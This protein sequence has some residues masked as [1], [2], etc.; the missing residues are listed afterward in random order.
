MT[1]IVVT[2]GTGTLGKLVVPALGDAKVRILSRTASGPDRFACDLMTGEG[3][4]PA[5]DGADVVVHLAGGPK[6]DDVATANLV[7]AAERAGACHLVFISVI[8]ADAVPLGYF[9]RKHEAEKLVAASEVPSTTLRAAQFHGFCL[10]A[11]RAAAKLPIVPVPA[12][13]VQPV[14]AR[15]VAGR[16]ARLALGDPAG[17]VRDLAGPTVYGMGELVDKYVRARGLRR[18]KMPMRVPGAAGKVYRADGN[19]N[20][21][22]DTGTRTFEDYLAEL[23]G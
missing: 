3:L 17:R 12:I 8:A 23:F 18:L 21:D 9:R 1:T 4:A 11:V 5:L 7:R 2:G 15:E 6:G 19:L 16:I 22:A 14:D 13:N 20:L 10:N